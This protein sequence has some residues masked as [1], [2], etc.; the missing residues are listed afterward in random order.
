[1]SAAT[2]ILKLS[3]EARRLG[4]RVDKLA[5]HWR[6]TMPDGESVT[7]STTPGSGTTEAAL[8]RLLRRHREAA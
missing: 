2:E 3:R 6:W 8:R 1:M 4:I 5:R 7:I